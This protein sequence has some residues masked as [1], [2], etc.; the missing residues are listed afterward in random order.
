MFKFLGE[1][2]GTL[3]FH[4]RDGDFNGVMQCE[5]PCEFVKQMIFYNSKLQRKEHIRAVEGSIAWAITR[6]AMNGYLKKFSK[7]RDGKLQEVWFDESGPKW[8][9]ATGS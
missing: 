9:P 5:R 7:E 8:R 6:D 4:T 2:E 3:Q 1:R